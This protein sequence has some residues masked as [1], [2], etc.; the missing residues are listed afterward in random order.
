MEKLNSLVPTEHSLKLAPDHPYT[1]PTTIKTLHELFTNK[2]HCCCNFLIL[3]WV[4]CKK[5]S[6]SNISCGFL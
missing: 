3:S 2:A 6:K 1:R 4:Q 5:P